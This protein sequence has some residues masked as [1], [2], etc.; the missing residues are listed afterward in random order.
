MCRGARV[1]KSL[2]LE[3]LGLNEIKI[4]IALQLKI[5]EAEGSRDGFQD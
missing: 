5:L 3:D 4:D 1:T 2:A